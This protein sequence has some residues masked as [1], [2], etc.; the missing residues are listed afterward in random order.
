LET[1]RQLERQPRAAFDRRLNIE[2]DGCL[3]VADVPT[4]ALSVVRAWRFT[5]KIAVVDR[6]ILR[7]AMLGAPTAVRQTVR[8]REIERGSIGAS[9]SAGNYRDIWQNEA[10]GRCVG[11]R[12]A[13]RSG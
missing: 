1:E 13:S 6:A 9:L 10:S 7:A 12:A 11:E 8:D 4:C 5:Q 3:A 2:E